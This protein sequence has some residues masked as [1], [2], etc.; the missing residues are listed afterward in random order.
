MSGVDAYQVLQDM[1]PKLD[2]ALVREFRVL[3][4]GIN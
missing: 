3:A 2:R 4:H 1:G